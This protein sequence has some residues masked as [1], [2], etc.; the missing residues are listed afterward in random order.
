MKK[1][2]VTLISKNRKYI[3][4]ADFLERTAPI[5]SYGFLYKNANVISSPNN[6]CHAGLSIGKNRTE[7]IVAV[8]NGMQTIREGITEESYRR[9]FEWLFNFSPYA[10][11][12][13]T[14]SVRSAIDNG[15]YVVDTEFPG[16]FVGGACQAQRLTTEQ[17]S[18]F[19][20]W[21]RLT[22][23]GCNPDVAFVLAYKMLPFKS[24]GK[25]FLSFIDSQHSIF[26]GI[27]WDDL[28]WNFAAHKQISPS[29]PY[30]KTGQYGTPSLLWRKPNLNKEDP[31]MKEMNEFLQKELIP[32]DGENNNPFKKP[33]RYNLATRYGFE[34]SMEALAPFINAYTRKKIGKE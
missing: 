29:G 30:N 28:I 23:Y 33:D 31:I 32:N 11:G 14:K 26:N 3:K 12:I 2:F 34:E 5:C 15:Y 9:F 8:L 13:S 7:G 21:D 1:E 17:A 19:P 18:A 10:P 6:V 27:T 22:H 16:N 24:A 4:T 20:V 25:F